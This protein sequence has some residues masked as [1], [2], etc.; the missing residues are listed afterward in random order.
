MESE[1]DKALMDEWEKHMSDFVPED[2]ST[3]VIDPKSSSVRNNK[4]KF[5]GVL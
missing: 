1:E 2:L 5:L 3:V 4:A